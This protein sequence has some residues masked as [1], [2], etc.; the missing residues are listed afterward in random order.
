M[1]KA[2]RLI[3]SKSP[4]LLQ[5]AYNPVDWQ[6]WND[7]ALQQAVEQNKPI[8]V[9]IGYSACH[10]CH[11]MEKESFEDDATAE[12]MNEHFVCIKIDREE[13][14]DLDNIYMDAVQAMGLNGGWPL[15]VFLLPNQKPFYGGTYFPNKN[16]KALLKNISQ[17]FELH[18][19]KLSESADGF[20]ETLARLEKDKY[21]LSDEQ[22]ETN[23]EVIHKAAKEILRQFDDQWGGLSRS[24]KFPMPAIWEFLLSYAKIAGN[25]EVKDKVLFTLKKIG[26]GGIYDHIG[27]G[28][29]RYSVDAEWFAP[30]FE[31]MLYDNG[32]LLSLYAKAYQSS[33]DEFFKEKIEETIEWLKNDML[34]PEGGF[35]AAID[36]DSEG[37]E[38]KFYTWK[39]QNLK[40]LLGE[41]YDWFRDLYNIKDPG[42]WE[43]GANILFQTLDYNQLAQKSGFTEVDLHTK[44]KAIKHLLYSHRENRPKPGLDDKILTGWNA[45][46][47]TGLVDCYFAY[48]KEEYKTLALNAARFLIEKV[49]LN[50]RLYRVYKEGTAYNDAFLEDYAALIE[51]LIK[52]YQMT[53]DVNWLEHSNDMA[54]MVIKN[55]LDKEEPLL[56]FNNP[57]AERLIANKKEIFDNVIPS[58]NAKMARNLHF[59]GLYYYN[60][61]YLNLSKRM[62]AMVNK[63]ILSDPTF[64][65]HWALH[66]LETH[67]STGEVAIVGSDA[68]KLSEEFA[69]EFHP[70]AIFGFSSQ[71]TTYPPLLEGKTFEVG[72]SRIFVCFNQTCKQPVGTVQ[73]AL[74][75]LPKLN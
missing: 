19:D 1:K 32:Q 11:V 35:N 43:D 40:D 55:F 14:P 64:M 42:N 5:H 17:A 22:M 9:S 60:N 7:N 46:A 68:E 51:A 3:N 20:G 29:A 45:L 24:P 39:A 6:E 2:N 59:L 44:L 4:Y 33:G 66:Y 34:Q 12:L 71:K 75:Q 47:I 41:D 67:L 23:S 27:G 18:Y 65:A 30:H 73:E 70:N 56:Y 25:I 49:Y 69:A 52:L 16:F 48:H 28:F 15:N 31:K 53:G 74:N 62:L 61:E 36:A 54:G 57:K 10:W 37:E 58:S 13:R 38:G 63:L 21:G 72:D 26:M 50:G 8:L